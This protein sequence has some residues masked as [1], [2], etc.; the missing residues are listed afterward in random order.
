[1]KKIAFSQVELDATKIEEDEN[2]IR[3]PAVLARVGVLPYKQGKAFRPED[4]LRKSLFTFEGAWTTSGKHPDAAVDL[5]ILT[6]PRDISGKTT[7]ITWDEGIKGVRGMV[8]LFKLSNKPEFLVDVKT[9]KRKDVSI[10]FL[11]REDL[12]KGVHEGQSYDFVQRDILINHVAVG[13]PV[14][15]ATQAGIPCTLEVDD[16]GEAQ[17]AADPWE[18]TENSIRS[19][20]GNKEKYDPDSFRTIDITSGIQA[21]IACPKGKWANGKCQVG[22]EVQS[23]IFDKTK[24]D[25]T[26]AKAWFNAHGGGDAVLALAKVIVDSTSGGVAAI[27]LVPSGGVGATISNSKKT[28]EDEIERT[29]KLLEMLPSS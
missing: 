29:E 8:H 13:V 18:T 25:M 14:G 17:V 9:G 6:S 21:V 20:H 24:F 27:V 19:G 2:E 10:G 22:T 12:Q 4:E 16:Y 15:R 7:N 28:P 23:Y 1:M 26:K 5:P 3:I 11:Y